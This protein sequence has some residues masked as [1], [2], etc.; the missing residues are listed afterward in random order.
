M[1]D[2]NVVS[3][4]KRAKPHGAVLEWII[5]VPDE[6]IFLPAVVAGEI[7]IGSEHARKNAVRKADALS[8]WLAALLSSSE[9]IDLSPEVFRI[10]GSIVER[11]N[12]ALVVD[13]LIAATALHHDMIVVTR[14]VRDFQQFDVRI[15][16]PFEHRA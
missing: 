14:N 3:E 6:S 9:W 11:G 7:Q 15:L 16:N 10:W 13:A 5:S 12:P 8:G 4:L 1:L 2:T